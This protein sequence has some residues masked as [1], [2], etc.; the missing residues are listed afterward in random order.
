MNKVLCVHHP[1]GCIMAAVYTA[2][3]N[4]ATVARFRTRAKML[5]LRIVEYDERPAMCC[6]ECAKKL[7]TRTRATFVGVEDEQIM[8][9]RRAT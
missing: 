4:P 1:C 5:E 8:E 9:R 2:T 7:I 6:A 3:A